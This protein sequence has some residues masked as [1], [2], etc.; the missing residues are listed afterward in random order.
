VSASVAGPVSIAA[1]AA[2]FAIAAVCSLT[3][4]YAVRGRARTI[5]LFD[6]PERIGLA[7][8]RPRVDTPRAG[9]P[10]IG[11]VA[12]TVAVLATMCA[13]IPYLVGGHWRDTR[14]LI[15]L[16]VG[17]VAMHLVGLTDDLRPLRARSKFLLQIIVASLVCAAGIRLTALSVPGV[18]V[19]SLSEPLGAALTVAWLVAITNAINLIDGLDGLAGGATVFALMGLFIFARVM[20]RADAALMS[21]ALAGATVGFLYFNFYPATIFLG[22]SGSLFL[23]FMLGGVGLLCVQAGGS[24]APAG[25]WAAAPIVVLGLPLIDTSLAVA[26]RL[27]G[28]RPIFSPDRGHIHHQLLDRFLARGYSPRTAVLTLYVLCALFAL[29][30]MGLVAA[31]PAAR[32]AATEVSAR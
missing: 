21:M 25:M 7:G 26:R 13:T 23:G 28:G 9:I 10:R 8:M 18:G 27:A 14:G 4:T 5:G 20:G 11:G 31:A 17:G 32:T 16:L 6:W 3:L 1:Y 12:V 15:V 2:A 24:P 19:V 30:G 22:D 29:C